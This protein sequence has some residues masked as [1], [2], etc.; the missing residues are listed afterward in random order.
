MSINIWHYFLISMAPVLELRGGIPLAIG[1]GIPPA[2]AFAL[3]A[4]G[5]MLPVPFIILFIRPVFRRLRRLRFLRG[6]IER[7]ESLAFRKSAKLDRYSFWALAVF[8]GIPLPGTGAWTG[9][10]IAALLDMD[11]KRALLAIFLGVLIAGFLVT[12]ISTGVF[13]GVGLLK[14][15]FFL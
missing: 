6:L 7:L 8:V 1:S 2:A 4:T 5:N 14:E 11:F 3:C 10:L 15:I 9:A 13:A 12:V